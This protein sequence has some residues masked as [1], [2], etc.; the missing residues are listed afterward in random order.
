MTAPGATGFGAAFRAVYA[1]QVSRAR[2]ARASLFFVATLQSLGLV[3]LL[4]GVVDDGR[5][6]EKQHIVAGSVVLVIAFVALN[7]LAQRFGL[8]RATGA[9]DYY[10]ALPVPPAAVVLGIVASYATF[11]VPGTVV[12]AVAGSLLYDLPLMHLW[13]LAPV[14]VVG[15]AALAGIGAAVG[16]AAPRPEMATVFG[17]LGMTLVLF[18]GLIRAARMPIPLRVVRAAMPSSYAVDALAEALAVNPSYAA[19]AAD[20]A[21]CAAAAIAALA[22]AALSYRRAVSR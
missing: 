16:L 13:V 22:V 5:I 11:A 14:V 1:G 17:Q 20:L 21:I 7:L 4:R 6:A 12:V 9:L 10:A 18:L 19:I 15:G 2:T 8:L 3:L